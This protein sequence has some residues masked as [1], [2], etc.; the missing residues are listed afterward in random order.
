MT[1][2]SFFEEKPELSITEVYRRFKIASEAS[3]KGS[4]D[5][6]VKNLQFLFTS[7]SPREAKYIARLAL[8]E[9]RIGVGEGVVRDAIAKAFSVPA[10]IVEHSF[11]VTN[12]LGIVAAAAK[13][14]GGVEALER[15]GIEINRPIKMMLSQI[16]PDIDADIR[17]MKEVAIE[18]KFDGGARV[19]IHKDGNSV[20]LFRVNLKMLP[21]PSLTSLK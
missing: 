4:Q 16:S 9:L 8:E 14:G 20:T 19:Q 5:I 12:D 7:S 10:E 21:V 2:S 1:F 17:A 3:G 11:M 18:W 13:K 15:L 6:K